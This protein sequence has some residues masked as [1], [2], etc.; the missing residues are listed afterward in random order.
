MCMYVHTYVRIEKPAN[1]SMV[2]V[3][4]QML[5]VTPAHTLAYS[6][7]LNM[8]FSGTNTACFG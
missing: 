5:F 3:N 6:T 7:I 8:F 4:I 2:Q 1:N